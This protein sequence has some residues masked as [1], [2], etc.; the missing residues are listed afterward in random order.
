M[1]HDVKLRWN[2]FRVKRAR[3]LLT[4]PHAALGDLL[5]NE[6]EKRGPRPR[7]MLL[8]RVAQQ[9]PHNRRPAHS[10]AEE[11]RRILAERAQGVVIL[12]REGVG[13]YTQRQFFGGGF[14]LC[15]KAR[16]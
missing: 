11:V 14:R 12:P 1:G 8:L 15:H 7:Q 2:M 16:Y 13:P 9:R 5:L 10:P 4:P 3:L 6:G